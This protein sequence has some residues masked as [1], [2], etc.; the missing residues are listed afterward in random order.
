[1]KVEVV[2][3]VHA[4]Y[5]SLYPSLLPSRR[6]TLTNHVWMQKRFGRVAKRSLHSFFFKLFMHIPWWKIY[7][8]IL[9]L[10]TRTARIQIMWGNPQRILYD[11]LVQKYLYIMS[12]C[13][14]R[15]QMNRIHGTAK[16]IYIEK[17]LP[18]IS[19]YNKLK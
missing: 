18:F 5:P 16:E 6:L 4:R 13:N 3:V 15:K 1:M 14:G 2:T 8:V 9:R 10:V 7:H 19:Q 17:G 11:E 12:V